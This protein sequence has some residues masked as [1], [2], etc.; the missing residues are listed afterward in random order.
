MKKFIWR[1]WL[2]ALW[3]LARLKSIIHAAFWYD[4]LAGF[5]LLGEASVFALKAFIMKSVHII[6]GNLFYLKSIDY[7]CSS[8]LQH[9]F[10]ATCRIGFGQT[11]NWA[12]SHKGKHNI[13]HYD[14]FAPEPNLGMLDL[15]SFLV[16]KP[17]SSFILVFH[18][19]VEWKA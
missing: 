2:M 14:S 7:K 8:H 12:P 10:T 11:D 16:S 4:G 9:N 19:C 5:L 15:L 13:S 18:C 1:N 3:D 17:F 6:E